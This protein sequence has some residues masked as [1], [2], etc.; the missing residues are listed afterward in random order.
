[1]KNNIQLV[2]YCNKLY[3]ASARYWFGTFGQIAS[4]SLWKVKKQQY[5]SQY[6][7]AD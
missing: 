4:N 1:M 2:E 6:N 7:A 5:P 3:N